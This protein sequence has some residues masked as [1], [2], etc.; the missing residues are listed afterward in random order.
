MVMKMMMTLV[1]MTE[2][3]TGSKAGKT[4]QGMKKVQASQQSPSY[5]QMSRSNTTGG[6]GM[7][8]A[9]TD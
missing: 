1:M 9:L 8:D 2:Q 4:E 5:L 7:N 6:A 3:G